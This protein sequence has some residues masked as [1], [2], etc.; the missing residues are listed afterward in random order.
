[1]LNKFCLK[2]EYEI[3]HNIEENNLSPYNIYKYKLRSIPGQPNLGL[4]KSINNASKKEIKSYQMQIGSLLFL[5][6][7]TRIDILYT[8]IMLARF[9][10]NPDNSHINALNWLWGY[11]IQHPN[12]AIKYNCSGDLK[13][14]GYTDSDWAGDRD[15]RKSTTGYIFC[16]NNRLTTDTNNM[17]SWNSMLQKTIALS[18]T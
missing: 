16:L 9:A 14:I 8:V 18:S 17:I 10:S 2:E 11:L 7:K 4:V 5:A 6:L 15:L 3:E 12:K 1:L 13:L